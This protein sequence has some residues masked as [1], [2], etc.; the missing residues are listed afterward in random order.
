MF[1]H[2]QNG[3][4][5]LSHESTQG[6]CTNDALYVE[7]SCHGESDFPDQTLENK[8]EDSYI[9]LESQNRALDELAVTLRVEVC[10][11]T[12]IPAAS[13]LS[14]ESSLEVQSSSTLDV[15]VCMD[16]STHDA[17][18]HVGGD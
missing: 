14:V 4:I 1:S 13:T 18:F 6:L 15:E 3:P 5:E 16:E 17:T 11:D 9:D 10:E 2:V 7:D 12:V 8:L